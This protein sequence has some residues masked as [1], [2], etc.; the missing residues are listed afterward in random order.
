M[1]L[2]HRG[3]CRVRYENTAEAIRVAAEMGADGV[4]L[5]V[6]MTLDEKLILCHDES[7]K[8]TVLSDST[9]SDLRSVDLDG[10]TIAT[11]EEALD[12]AGDL[13]V[14]LELKRPAKGKLGVFANK[15][16]DVVGGFGGRLIVSSFFT[17]IL[18]VVAHGLPRGAKVGVLSGIAYD[19][20]GRLAVEAAAS[21]DYAVALPQDPAVTEG[22]VEKAHSE[23]LQAITWTV[24]DPARIRELAS[25]GIDGIITNEPDVA[26]EALS[27]EVDVS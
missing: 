7:L 14:N 23:G 9:L 1:I 25:M 4:E 12:V 18:E 13:L 24:D 11:V 10:L 21:R 19:S 27:A 5:D 20:D 2:A 22:T 8:G 26:L 17:E 16:I 15:F 3:A 6:R